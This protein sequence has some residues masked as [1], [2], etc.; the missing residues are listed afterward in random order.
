[1]R[2]LPFKTSTAMLEPFHAH[3]G[4]QS[5]CA[6]SAMR[7]PSSQHAIT[8]N[9]QPHGLYFICRELIRTKNP[10][11]AEPFLFDAMQLTHAVLLQYL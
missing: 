11:S 10:A 2:G 5:Y 4:W 1:M 7:N 8:S 6:S 3:F 9:P